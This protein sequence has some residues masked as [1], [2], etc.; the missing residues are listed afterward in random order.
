[1][2]LVFEFIPANEKIGGG[3]LQSRRQGA[4]ALCR[5]S[6]ERIIEIEQSFASCHCAL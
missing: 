2:A 6:L 5:Q 4:A 1:M 3:N